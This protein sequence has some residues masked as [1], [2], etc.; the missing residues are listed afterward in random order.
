MEKDSFGQC[1]A[2]VNSSYE[3]L[4]D[5]LATLQQLSNSIGY[6]EVNS[7]GRQAHNDL[8]NLLE[9][10]HDLSSWQDLVG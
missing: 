1:S 9:R 8:A 10:L 7:L 6:H 5:A 4:C 2:L 3:Q